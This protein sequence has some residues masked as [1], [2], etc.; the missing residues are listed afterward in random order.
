MF[1]IKE[2][3]LSPELLG[4]MSKVKIWYG[5]TVFD[6]RSLLL[7]LFRGDG[8]TDLRVE[9]VKFTGCRIREYNI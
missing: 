3:G 6:H 9:K 1:K 5:F 8:V 7:N 2:H 4:T